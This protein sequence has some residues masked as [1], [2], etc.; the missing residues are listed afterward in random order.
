MHYP[1]SVETEL[2]KCWQ[3]SVK[4]L[5]TPCHPE[6]PTGVKDPMLQPPPNPPYQ[7]VPIA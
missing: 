7:P 6:R 4:T 2:A 1:I 5:R 3:L